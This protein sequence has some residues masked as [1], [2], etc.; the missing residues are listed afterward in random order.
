[1]ARLLAGLSRSTVG[2]PLQFL[3]A[4]LT[5]RTLLLIHAIFRF[6]AL[7]NLLGCIWWFVAELEGLENSWAAASKHESD[8]SC[9]MDLLGAAVAEC[10]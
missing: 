8:D 5:T 2:G 10:S 7:V 1:V 9:L 6:C 4:A 3:A